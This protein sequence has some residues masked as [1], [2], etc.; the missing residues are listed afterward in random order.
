MSMIMLKDNERES[1]LDEVTDKYI[2]GDASHKELLEAERDY[3]VDYASA[4][5]ELARPSRQLRVLF[6]KWFLSSKA[7]KQSH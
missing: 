4:I 2:S 6:R 3:G 5:L 1:R 7:R